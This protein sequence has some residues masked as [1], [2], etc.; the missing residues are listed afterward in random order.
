MMG[1][2]L[3]GQACPPRRSRIRDRDGYR[4][5]LVVVNHAFFSKLLVPWIGDS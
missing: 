5:A 2:G 1:A 4:G 3:G